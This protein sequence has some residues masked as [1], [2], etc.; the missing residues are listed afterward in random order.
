MLGGLLKAAKFLVGGKYHWRAIPTALVGM[1]LLS[2][3]PRMNPAFGQMS[4]FQG[5]S[6][7]MMG[8][9]MMGPGMSGMSPPMMGAG[10]M[11]P[12]AGVPPTGGMV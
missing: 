5:M 2:P 9:G 4:A 3:R 1:N 10:G 12:N 11:N 6:P 8:P 7:G